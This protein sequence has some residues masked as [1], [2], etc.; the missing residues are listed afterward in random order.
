L[1]TG[2]LDE[3]QMMRVGGLAAANQ[4]KLFGQELDISGINLR[5]SASYKRGTV[6]DQ[7]TK[8]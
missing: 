7:Q 3:A 8:S 2:G 5:F 1:V 6:T 4:P